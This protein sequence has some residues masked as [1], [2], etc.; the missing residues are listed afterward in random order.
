MGS[1]ANM[2]SGVVT[3][4]LN[5]IHISDLNESEFITAA[6]WKALDYSPI[7]LFICES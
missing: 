7:V 4:P 5:P 2:Q 3:Q 1:T 6:H